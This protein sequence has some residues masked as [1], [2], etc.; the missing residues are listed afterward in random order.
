VGL[1]APLTPP[2]KTATTTTVA[3]VKLT[4]GH[5]KHVTVKVTSGNGDVPTGTVSLTGG[6]KT[7]G[8]GTLSA[9]S[10]SVKIDGRAL[11]PGS[12]TV[13][14]SYAGDSTHAASSGTAI[15][16]VKKATPKLAVTVKPHKVKVHKTRVTLKIEASAAL[17]IVH[18]KVTVKVGRYVYRAKLVRGKAKIKLQA[19]G[20]TG[21]QKVVVR[22]LG[23]AYNHAVK[24]VVHVKVRR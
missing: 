1:N 19:F 9:G 8:A 12:Y 20:S 14:A 21:S 15:L 4:Y 17:Q 2:G 24:K 11:R 6:G 13:T 23:D 3:P 5:S 18:G 10:T 7:L 22:Y 16:T